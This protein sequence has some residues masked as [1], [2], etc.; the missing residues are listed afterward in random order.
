M[1][2]TFGSLAESVYKH[3]YAMRFE[4]GGAESWDDTARR[5]AHS[6]MQPY[7][8][9]KAEAAYRLIRDRKFLPGGRYLY[10]AGRRYHQ[11]N[12]CCLLRAYDSREAWGDLMRRV[13]NAL[14]TGM[15]VG[16]VYSGVRARGSSVGGLGGVAT[17]PCSLMQMVNETGR[18]IMQGGSRRSAIWAGLRWNHPDV[19]EF[20]HLKDWPGWMREAKLKDFNA[21]ATMDGTNISVG[22]DD[23]FFHAYYNPAH[24][25]H[26]LARR[27]YR[28]VVE[29]M[30]R[31]GEPG[32]S[33]DVGPH[34]GEDLRNAPVG[35]RTLVLT[36]KGYV[37]VR[38]VVDEDV[39]VWTG[40]RW[41]PTRF[42]RTGTNVPTV[43]VR[44]GDLRQVVCDPSHPFVR[45]NDWDV[46]GGHVA[47][48][49]A[50][51]LVPGDR[52]ACYGNHPGVVM[53]VTADDNQDVYCCDVGV[54]EHTFV[55]EGLIVG[56]CTEVTSR[57]DN[58]ICNL[59]SLV[60][61]RFRD[62]AEFAEA[63]ETATAFL[64]CGTLYSDLPLPE[65]GHVREKNRRLGLG[66]M[67]FHE[68]LL[69]RGK[70]YGPD[71]EL[72]GWLSAY[73]EVSDR[74]ARD[75]ADRLSVSRPVAKRAIAPTG[76]IAIIAE[77]TSGIEPIFAVAFMRRYLKGDRWHAQY[78]VDNAAERLIQEGVD[79][80]S[81]EDAYS[82]A[83]DPGRRLAFQSFVQG[84]VDQGISSTL[85]LPAWGTPANNPDTVNDFAE[86]LMDHLPHLRGVT[87]Y[88]DGARGGQPLTVVPYREAIGKLGV[89]VVEYGNETA[90]PGGVCGV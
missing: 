49:R 34:A 1:A 76:T 58:D 45:E 57:D 60:L 65:L 36:N 43:C 79:P 70:K 15:G 5:V 10:A 50:D 66:L 80:A 23:A 33:I 74:A 9:E 35:G 72:G 29:Q 89:E 4:G 39:V 85:N 78:V 81:I 2:V 19:S 44:L 27:V 38:S 53:A 77:T 67:G 88:P 31:T 90:C 18:H 86:V 11:V 83:G 73:R 40:R 71:G 20:I 69:R 12:N 8:P 48:V 21:A 16:V 14:M 46:N 24:P 87:A 32:F 37:P 28:T 59:G 47:K 22:L 54:E 64:V 42:A 75:A 30:C 55:A 84:Y 63:V 68:W 61:P 17:G 62:D 13:T 3:K 52:L 41:A 25:E 7:L 56:N 6:V 51:S 82:L 26:G